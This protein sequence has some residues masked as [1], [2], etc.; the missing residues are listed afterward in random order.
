M[1]FDEMTSALDPELVGEV[2]K[3][4]GALAEQGMTMLV[5]IHEMGFARDVADEVIF[6]DRGIIVEHVSSNRMFDHPTEAHTR[7]FLERLL[8]REG[9]T[10]RGLS[11]YPSPR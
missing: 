11:P 3:A 7:A 5:V 8:E 2:L 6:M 4:M 9:G 10:R 1:L